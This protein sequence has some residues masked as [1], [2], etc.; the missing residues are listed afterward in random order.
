MLGYTVEDVENMIVSLVFAYRR[1][2]VEEQHAEHINKA[3]DL[4]EGLL[5]EGHI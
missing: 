4:L 3:I 5:A 1:R 2:V